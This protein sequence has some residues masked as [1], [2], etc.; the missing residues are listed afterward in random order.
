MKPSFALERAQEILFMLRQGIEQN[1]LPLSKAV[2][3]DS[4]MAIDATEIFE[5][6]PDCYGPAVA[7]MFARHQ[8][9]FGLPGLHIVRR[10]RN[11]S[12]STASAVAP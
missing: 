5:R 4:P 6:H 3:L 11:R 2:F 1:R 12:R 8:D 10:Q 7:E 9:P